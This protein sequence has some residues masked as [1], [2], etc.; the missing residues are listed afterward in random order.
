M[1]RR[2]KERLVGASILVAL[3]VLIAPELLSGPSP[4]PMSPRLP[5]SAPEP[6]RHVTVDLATAKEPEPESGADA[7]A[8]SVAPTPGQGAAGAAGAVAQTGADG[9]TVGNGTIPPAAVAATTPSAT[10]AEPLEPASAAPTSV[11]TAKPVKAAAPGH[12]W[13][14]QLGSFASRA[15]AEKLMH[16][17]KAQGFSA[18]LSSIGSGASARHRVRIGPLADRNAATQVAAKLRSLGHVGS[19]VPP[20]G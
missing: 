8:S 2:V 9:G 14:V 18:Y 20:A 1:E 17:V 3:I 7:A 6:V 12:A 5:A 4:A 15:N 16:Q 10:T 13:A 11:P 19:V